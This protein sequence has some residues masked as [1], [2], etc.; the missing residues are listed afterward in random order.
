MIESFIASN[1][2]VVNPDGT[3]RTLTTEKDSRGVYKGEFDSGKAIIDNWKYP[4]L[5]RNMPCNICSG[6][7]L[8]KKEIATPIT[9][10]ESDGIAS[11]KGT[12]MTS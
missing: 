5:Q 1:V 3:T 6:Q 4:V 9:P 2:K 12:S 10:S 7:Y 11:V 8:C